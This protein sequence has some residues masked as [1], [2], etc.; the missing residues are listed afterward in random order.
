M[1]GKGRTAARKQGKARSTSCDVGSGYASDVSCGRPCGGLYLGDDWP[2]VLLRAF[3]S[4]A[5]TTLPRYSW[6]LREETIIY[7]RL[8]AR[9][10]EVSWPS[11]IVNKR[12]KNRCLTPFP[13]SHAPAGRESLP[14]QSI[15]RLRIS[16]LASFFRVGRA[17]QGTEEAWRSRNRGG[18]P[19]ENIRP[20]AESQSSWIF[21][22][23][24]PDLRWRAGARFRV[25]SAWPWRRETAPAD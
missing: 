19:R 17:V 3:E 13:C 20:D 8:L 6:I 16:P 2:C 7:N 23:A 4:F 1:A 15:P 18:V 9:S 24:Y 14:E 12:L 22:T 11:G 10:Q 5:C 21:G 25:L